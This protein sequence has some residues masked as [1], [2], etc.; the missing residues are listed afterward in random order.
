M[1]SKN[2]KVKTDYGMVVKVTIDREKMILLDA[3]D[4]TLK[5]PDVLFTFEGEGES[6]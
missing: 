3:E 6:R 5:M 1:A 2:G 4:G